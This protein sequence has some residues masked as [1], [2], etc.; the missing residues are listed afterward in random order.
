LDGKQTTN[1]SLITHTNTKF[2][3]KT[4]IEKTRSLPALLPFGGCHSR[5]LLGA[6]SYTSLYT[7]ALLPALIGPT[8]P[9][10]SFDTTYNIPHRVIGKTGTIYPNG[11]MRTSQWSPILKFSKLKHA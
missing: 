5:S 7:L 4:Q 2:N 3:V 9:R 11:S 6:A 10:V 8:S 1:K